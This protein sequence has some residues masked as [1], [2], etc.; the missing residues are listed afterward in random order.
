[1]VVGGPGTH[2]PRMGDAL[3][4]SGGSREDLSWQQWEVSC[5]RA[6]N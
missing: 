2:P 3:A 4:V 1:M 6:E 5:P